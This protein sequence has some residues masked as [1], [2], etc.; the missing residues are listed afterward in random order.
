MSV[1]WSHDYEHLEN[2]LKSLAAGSCH[3]T[4]DLMLSRQFPPRPTTHCPLSTQSW[5]FTVLFLPTPH[6]T[7]NLDFDI[8]TVVKLVTHK[9][10]L[11][12][13]D[14]KKEQNTWA[15]NAENVWMEHE[16]LENYTSTNFIVSIHIGL[17]AWL[18]K[19]GRYAH[20]GEMRNTHGISP[21]KLTQAVKIPTCIRK[22]LAWNLGWDTG[23]TDAFLGL[24]CSSKRMPEY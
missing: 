18:N 1:Q 24:L 22:A 14:K 13:F 8:V 9:S 21:S 6:F 15:E 4:L 7:E 2:E 3:V 23:Y 17:F 20:K 12:S 10:C 11:I 16:N 5:T 19:E